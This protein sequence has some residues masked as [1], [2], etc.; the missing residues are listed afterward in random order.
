[1]LEDHKTSPFLVL[2]RTFSTSSDLQSAK[3]VLN[4]LAKKILS[5]VEKDNV[6]YHISVLWKKI[7]FNV[8]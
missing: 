2:I 5:R 4:K 6:E 8:F 1:M 3:P 7:S